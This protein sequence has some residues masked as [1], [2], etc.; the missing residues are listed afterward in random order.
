MFKTKWQKRYENI[1][2]YVKSIRD[3][4]EQAETIFPEGSVYSEC[5]NGQKVV[6]NDVLRLMEKE[7]ES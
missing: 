3:Y 7:I 1:Y 6:L 5:R 4:C 2:A